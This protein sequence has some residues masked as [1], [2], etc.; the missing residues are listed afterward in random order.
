MRDFISVSQSETR[1]DVGIV[2]Y[3]LYIRECKGFDRDF[4]VWEASSGAVPL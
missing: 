2:P 4:E 1:D 3:K